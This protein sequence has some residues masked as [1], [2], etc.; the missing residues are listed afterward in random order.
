MNILILTAA[1]DEIREIGD[2]SAAN[3]ARYARMHGYDFLYVTKYPEWNNWQGGDRS[4]YKI[5]LLQKYL[6][7]Y[8]WVWWT[9]ADCLIRNFYIK[10]E[11]I[12]A[13]D[14]DLVIGKD[15][16]PFVMP[17][18]PSEP[19]ERVGMINCGSFFV[20][21]CLW[22]AGFLAQVANSTWIEEIGYYHR[23]QGAMI[24][25]L[26]DPYNESHVQYVPVRTFNSYSNYVNAEESSWKPQE[27]Y[28]VGDFVK[29]WAG[30]IPSNGAILMEMKM[31]CSR[32]CILTLCSGEMRKWIGDYSAMGKQSYATKW[33]YDFLYAT[34]L[35][36]SSRDGSWNKIPWIQRILGAYEWVFWSDADCIICNSLIQ[37]PYIIGRCDKDLIIGIDH[38]PCLNAGNFLIKNCDWSFDFLRRVY[39]RHDWGD[40]TNGRWN[41][42]GLYA[43][44]E[45]GV[46]MSFL[47][48]EP[49]R[50]HAAMYPVQHIGFSYRGNRRKG[51]NFS[52]WAHPDFYQRGDFIKH[53]GG[54]FCS[55]GARMRNMWDQANGGSEFVPLNYTWGK[56]Y[57][58]AARGSVD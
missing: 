6:A 24:R 29:H 48:T 35:I 55:E 13:T 42:G 27:V 17:T 36:D 25:L 8:D 28:Q 15:H 19:V 21:N 22:S 37:L 52:S 12:L 57:Q 46:M 47:E 38:Q 5:P 51:H 40:F 56:Q 39:D 49:D 31:P 23:E 4:W 30:T 9:D 32:F 41:R 7:S 18:R 3:K 43:E 10:L 58:F 44:R 2:I 50:S 16:Q 11:D 45:Q 34:E 53:Y 33:G 54:W 14:M 1:D 26:D 20:R